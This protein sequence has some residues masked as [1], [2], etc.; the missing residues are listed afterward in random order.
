MAQEKSPK[1][2]VKSPQK[3]TPKSKDQGKSK[4]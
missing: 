4:K 3:P 1:K 2:E